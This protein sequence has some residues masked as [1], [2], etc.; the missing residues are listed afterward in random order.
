M[1]FTRFTSDRFPSA[2]IRVMLTFVATLFVIAVAGADVASS[3]SRSV[4]AGN[5]DGFARV[6]NETKTRL[7]E[8]ASDSTLAAW[9]RHFLE[10]LAGADE[11]ASPR[12]G[13]GSP[14]AP[15]LAGFDPG[16]SWSEFAP[17]TR[18]GHTAIYDPVRDRMI[19]FGGIGDTSLNDTWALSLSC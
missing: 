5:F 13:S 8:A 9:Q 15:P 4:F 1:I 11:H 18:A 19:V 12:P 7:K 16:G 10:Q 6:N 3:Q 14:D 17:P 2:E